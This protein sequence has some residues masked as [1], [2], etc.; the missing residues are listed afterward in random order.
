MGIDRRAIELT[1]QLGEMGYFTNFESVIELGSQDLHFE[2]IDARSTIFTIIKD[3]LK[4]DDNLLQTVV[5]EALKKATPNEFGS[6]WLYRLIGFR[7]YQCIDGDGR[8]GANIWDLNYAVPENHIDKYDLVTNHG[9]TEHV[10][11]V[12][13]AFKNIHD[14][15]RANGIMLHVVPFQG[16]VNHGFF[17]F[18]PD[19][20]LDL[21]KENSYEIIQI[22]VTIGVWN[23][24]V[25]P[26][27]AETFQS[28]FQV[29]MDAN[30]E[31]VMRKSSDQQFKIPF[32]GIYGGVNCLLPGYKE[33]YT[34]QFRR[35]LI[36]VF[37][38]KPSSKLRRII[39]IIQNFSLNNEKRG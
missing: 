36:F 31:V 11:N 25:L 39:S 10:F 4:I 18:Q 2:S 1:L 30:L 22:N 28:A 14:L 37:F 13:Q 19:F 21:A 26:W 24:I 38:G 20:F 33:S 35:R 15:T 7:K 9:T 34:S 16:N 6:E 12:F 23:K 5:D 27:N 8:L 3:G 17:N 32:N 29:G